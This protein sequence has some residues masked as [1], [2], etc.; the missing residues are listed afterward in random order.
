VPSSPSGREDSRAYDWP[1]H[2]HG[3]TEA[4]VVGVLEQ[5]GIVPVV[6]LR[7]AGD[8]GPLLEALSAA[9]LPL[10]EITLRTAAA[11]EAITATRATHPNA[12]VGA[13][14]V[15]SIDDAR[16]VIEAGAQFVVSPATNPDVVAYCTSRAVLMMP[17]ACTP[18]EVDA[19]VRAGAAVVKFFPAEAIGGLPFLK[20]L[21]APFNDVR[22]VPTGG[23]NA[24]NLADYLRVPQ[25]IACGGS[26]MVNPLLLEQRR[27]GEV[28]ALAR[29]AVEIVA[30]VR[31]V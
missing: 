9:G 7:T 27:F 6:E 28:E 16:R 13:G 18:T 12:L 2:P 4:K 17:G 26:W 29:E 11:L 8:A 1:A 10:A 24:S 14:T 20:A 23:V 30:D 19:A 15:R 25:V 31:N 5:L 3:A 22:F 21:S